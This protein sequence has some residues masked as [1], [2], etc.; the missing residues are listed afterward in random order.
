MS[1]TWVD[2]NRPDEP[3]VRHAGLFLAL[4]LHG[5]LRVL[6]V[7]DVYQYLSQVGFA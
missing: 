4:G 1:K 5:H 7:T 2:Y 3:N 6:I